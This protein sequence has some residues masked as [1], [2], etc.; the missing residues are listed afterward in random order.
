MVLLQGR[1]PAGVVDDNVY[2]NSRAKRMRGAGEFAEL[3][4]ARGAFVELHQRGIHRCQIERG[5]GASETAKA[6]VGRRH[7]MHGQKMNDFAAKFID[8]ERQLPGEVAEGSRRRQRG[9][10]LR[11][12]RL[13]LR[14]QFL[15]GGGGEVFGRAE[16][17]REGAVNGV[18]RA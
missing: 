18:G 17:P 7:R 4:N 2:E 11:F 8:D 3:V 15:V 13:E 14:F 12:Q 6:R 16:Q 10:A 9:V 1:A 5:V